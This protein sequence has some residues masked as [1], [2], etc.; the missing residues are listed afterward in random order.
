MMNKKLNS[1]SKLY[2]YYH[3]IYKYFGQLLS[4]IQQGKM[5]SR[6]FHLKSL[7]KHM[8]STKYL[9]IPNIMYKMSGNGV[10]VKLLLLN[11]ICSLN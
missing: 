2:T 8:N 4:H 10:I 5:K 6:Y 11:P 3:I 7:K 9:G 1:V